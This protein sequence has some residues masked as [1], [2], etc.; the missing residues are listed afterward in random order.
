[1][2]FEDNDDMVDTYL[3]FDPLGNW[4]NDKNYTKNFLPFEQLVR[5]GLDSVLNIKGYYARN[6]VY[7]WEA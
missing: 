6:A 5:E 1:M 3:M 2:V 7:D 4:M